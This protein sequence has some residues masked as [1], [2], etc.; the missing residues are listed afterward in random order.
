MKQHKLKARARQLGVTLLELT[1]ILVILVALAGLMIPYFSGSIKTS[2]MNSTAVS[3]LA[4]MDKL[5]QSYNTMYLKE[6]NNMEAL[7]NGTA[8]TLPT[9]PNILPDPNC[10]GA[11]GAVDMLYCKMICTGC[12]KP[13]PLTAERLSSLNMAGITSLYYNNPNT[14]DATLTATVTPE[15]TLNDVTPSYVAQVVIPTAS[16]WAVKNPGA[17]IEDYLAAVFGSS[18]KKFDSICYD[19]VAFGIGNQ[20]SLT[21]TVMATAPVYFSDQIAT[22]DQAS[23]YNRFVAL[24]Q[25]DRIIAASPP[26]ATRK[27]CPP[28]IEPAKF[29]GSVIPGNSPRGPL[30]GLAVERSSAEKAPD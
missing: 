14:V 21:G 9:D 18:S 11:V 13:L 19:Y 12:F 24:F 20:S 1:V 29:I 30:I 7:I 23:T 10:T 8:Y 22:A 6:P 15:R 26:S 25:V 4:E 28:S 2:T 17:T 3:S 5:M 16:T 27:G